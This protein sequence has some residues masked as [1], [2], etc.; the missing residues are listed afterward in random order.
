MNPPLLIAHC[1]VTLA[2]VSNMIHLAYAQHFGEP[3]AP[4]DRLW[5]RGV[6]EW[7]SLIADVEGRLGVTFH[8]SDIEFLDTI[9]DLVECGVALLLRDRQ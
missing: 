2:R 8:D 9:D 4:D 6:D 1:Q 7:F 3:P 5:D